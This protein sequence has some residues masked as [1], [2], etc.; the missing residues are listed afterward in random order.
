VALGLAAI[1]AWLWLAPP[2][3]SARGALR[4]VAALVL[5]LALVDAGC[6]RAGAEG[7]MRALV[8]VDRSFS[9]ETGDRDAAAR[10]WLGRLDDALEGWRVEH[11]SFGG[12]TTDLAAAIER[13]EAE[14]PD[15]IVVVTDGRAAGGRAAEAPTTPLYVHAPAP[16]AV[17]DLAIVDVVVEESE[18]RS[19]ARV[20][21]AAVGGRPAPAR[22]VTV[23]VAGRVAARGSLGDMPLS[24]GERRVTVVPLAAV[25]AGSVVEARLEGSDAVAGNDRRARVV[26]PGAGPRAA[27]LVALRPGWEFGFVRRA[28]ADVAPLEA[29]WA[30]APGR[31]ATLDGTDARAW[32]SLPPARYRSVWLFGDPAMLGEAGRAWVERFAGLGGRGVAWLPAGYA[33]ALP[34]AGAAVPGGARTSG[35]PALTEAGARWLVA[36][37]GRAVAEGS[38]PDGTAAWP[39]LELLPAAPFDLGPSAVP[40]IMAGGRPATWI[41]E[42]GARRVAVFLGTGYYRWRLAADETRRAFWDGWIVALARWLAG[43]SAV[44][45]PIVRLP[46]GGRLARGDTL[47]ATVVADGAL[48]WRV[49]RDGD[50]VARGRTESGTGSRIL[51]AGPFD[52]GIYRLVVDPDGSPRPASETFVV[53]TWAPDLAWTAADTASLGQ[54]ARASGGALLS[55]DPRVPQPTRRLEATGSRLLGFGTT[56]WTYVIVAL[57]LLADWGLATRSR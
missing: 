10:A 17:E 57:L 5:A 49:E 14:L 4:M 21:V 36:Q 27:L 20:E 2:R 16:L 35:E 54:A 56:P 9:M 13:A 30:P 33:G 37:G 28:L 18:Q 7:T 44:E 12:S 26:G 25:P 8:L 11:D 53:E 23:R 34:G 50:V 39:P 1:V 43:A 15:A 31:V 40:L 45:R 41:A 22:D 3:W 46:P 6:R 24:A 42:P 32:A 51:R 55:D 29:Y 38:A 47:V 48:E 52:P 19:A